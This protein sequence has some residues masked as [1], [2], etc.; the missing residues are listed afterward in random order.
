MMP[1]PWPDPESA[2]VLTAPLVGLRNQALGLAERAGLTAQARD[3]V[4]TGPFRLLPARFWPNPVA[5][6]GLAPATLPHL[7]IGCGGKSAAVNAA[8][9]ASGH[10][11]VQIQNPRLDPCRFDL[12]IVQPHDNLAGPNVVVTRTALHRVTPQ[13]L[14][15]AR[16]RWSPVFAGLQRPL[17][18]VLVGGGNGRFR[19]N[20]AVA[21]H[22]AAR[23]RAMMRA[24]HAG[25]ALT[26][27]RRTAPPA[28]AALREALAPDG[29]F[30]W[31]GT[32]ENPYLGLLACADAIIVTGDSVSM[33]SE[34]AATAVPVLV[35]PLPGRSRRIAA[36]TRVL[37]REGRIRRYQERL[38]T[39]NASPLDDTPAAAAALRALPRLAGSPYFPQ[40]ARLSPAA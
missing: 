14:A 32:G 28:M 25:L 24:D 23:L 15:A 17:V 38:E 9:H 1:E 22:L 18:S 12:V 37:E 29:T 30:L 4:P 35:A 13:A 19:L 21:A 8:L 31:D 2:L 11:A 5:T 27:S 34:A 6:A 10:C 26:F 3:L 7:V 20:R 40:S 16:A 33:I 39:W 36:F